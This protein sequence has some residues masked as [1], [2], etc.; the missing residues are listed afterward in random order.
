MTVPRGTGPQS[1]HMELATVHCLC[2]ANRLLVQ[3]LTFDVAQ[4]EYILVS[5][6][7]EDSEMKTLTFTASQKQLFR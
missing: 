4:H 3:N 6:L 2:T 5:R 1:G 7:Y